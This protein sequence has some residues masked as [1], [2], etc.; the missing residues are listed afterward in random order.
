MTNPIAPH[1]S[2]LKDTIIGPLLDAKIQADSAH[3]EAVGSAHSCWGT[4]S[5]ELAAAA[6][7]AWVA[8]RAST[9]EP[10]RAGSWVLDFRD[11]LCLSSAV[12]GPGTVVESVLRVSE[13]W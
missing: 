12:P 7:A 4:T 10:G 11:V 6:A 8:E 3:R 1:I 13:A 2:T 9:A 5:E